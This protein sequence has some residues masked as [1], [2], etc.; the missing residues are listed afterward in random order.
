MDVQVREYFGQLAEQ[1][2]VSPAQERQLLWDYLASVGMERS[3]AAY[4][5]T[6]LA[7]QLQQLAPRG[8]HSP[9]PESFPPGWQQR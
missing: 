5:R 6:Q 4:A 2:G 7:T 1:H 3:F 9:H 8:Y